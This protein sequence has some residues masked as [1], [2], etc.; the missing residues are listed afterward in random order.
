M[1]AFPGRTRATARFPHRTKDHRHGVVRAVVLR[2]E[3]EPVR[4]PPVATAG[5]SRRANGNQQWRGLTGAGNAARSTP[6]NPPRKGLEQ[7][8]NSLAAQC[9]ACEAFIRSQRNEGWVL[10]RTRYDDGGFSGGNVE[11]PALQDLITDISSTLLRAVPRPDHG[12]QP[13][14]VARTKPNLDTFPHPARLAH[15]RAD[16]NHLSAPIH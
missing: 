1:T 3:A 15:R 16:W 10:V 13:V 9:E 5:P 7:E 6:A 12:F 4:H 8:F 11:R 2:L 14:P